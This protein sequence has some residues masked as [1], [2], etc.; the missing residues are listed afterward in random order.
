MSPNI[1]ILWDKGEG[2]H[3]SDKFKK[4]YIDFTSG[5]FTTN[6]GHNNKFLQKKVLKVLKKGI[7]HSYHYFNNPRQKYI[8]ELINFVNKKI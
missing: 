8:E 5:I 4:K 2:V 1:K 6:I 3:V 7:T